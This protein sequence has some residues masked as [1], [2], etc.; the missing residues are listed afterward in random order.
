MGARRLHPPFA[1]GLIISARAGDLFGRRR[2][3]LLGMVG[4]TAASLACG[5]APSAEMLIA[6]RV[7]QGLFGAVMI[8]QGLAMVKSSFTEADLHK[9]FIPFGPVMGLSAVMGPILAGFLLDADLLGSGWRAIFWI[10]VPVGVVAAYLAGL[11]PAQASRP[12]RRSAARLDPLGPS[13]HRGIDHADLPA[14]AG[15]RAG[16]ARVDVRDARRQRGAVVGLRWSERRTS[17]PVVERSLMSNRSFLAGL[18][19]LGT[20]FTAMSGFMLTMNLFLQYGSGFAP[21]HTGLAF[22][23]W[24]LGM[25]VGAAVSG[26]VLGPRFGRHGCCT[27]GCSCSPPAWAWS[28]WASAPTACR[29]MGGTSPR[30]LRRRPGQRS[31]LRP[32]VRPHPRGPG[33]PRGGLRQWGAERRAAVLRRPRRGRAR[34]GVLQPAARA[35]VRGLDPRPPGDR[36]RL[37]RRQLRG[38]V[39]A[40]DRGTRRRRGG[41]ARDRVAQASSRT[42]SADSVTIEASASFSFCS[43]TRYPRDRRSAAEGGWFSRAM[44]A[45]TRGSAPPM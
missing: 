37:L 10:N 39:P 38:G 17:H 12:R 35:R 34:L 15:P 28:G 30:V 33:R 36:D 4:F 41:P 18:V 45:V 43:R 27:A 24:A 32:A 26:A 40:A 2:L 1:V 11:L 6:A 19:F 44:R 31:D 29:P 16:L 25:A 13:A 21:L 23:P 14:R 3:F 8:P 5:L 7:V 9:A 22:A 42:S 20:F